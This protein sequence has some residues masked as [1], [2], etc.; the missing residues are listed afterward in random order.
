MGILLYTRAVRVFPE[1][2]GPV[3]IV[4]ILLYTHEIVGR[5]W[6]VTEKSCTMC[7]RVYFYI[8]VV[9]GVLLVC[10]GGMCRSYVYGYTFI[11]P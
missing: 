6:D 2:R 5:L 11:Y 3:K 4:G 8:P 10:V 1:L 9:V 7:L